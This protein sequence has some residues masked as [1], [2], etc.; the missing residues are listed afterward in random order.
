M[1]EIASL[2][3]LEVVTLILG[4]GLWFYAE[5]RYRPQEAQLDKIA[6][7]LHMQPR[8]RR[9]LRVIEKTEMQAAAI[10]V[11][12]VGHLIVLLILGRYFTHY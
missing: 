1:L 3:G 10:I 8:L 11:L 2:I 7:I 5:K 12:V 9:K 6:E 4:I